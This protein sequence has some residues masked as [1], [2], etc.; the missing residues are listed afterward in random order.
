[1]APK[2]SVKGRTIRKV[3]GGA[4]NFRAAGID[5]YSK[6]QFTIAFYTQG[7]LYC[8]CIGTA[9]VYCIAEILHVNSITNK[10]F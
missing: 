4:G 10:T 7:I 1:M 6:V 9:Q 8:T 5:T 3:M 2:I